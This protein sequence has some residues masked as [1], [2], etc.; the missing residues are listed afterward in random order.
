VVRYLKKKNQKKGG[1]KEENREGV[2]RVSLENTEGKWYNEKR[3][4]EKVFNKGREGGA[5]TEGQEK[6]PKKGG[7]AMDTRKR[8]ETGEKTLG[9]GLGKKKKKKKE[10]GEG[11]PK[12][13]KVGNVVERHEGRGSKE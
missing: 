2:K 9:K 4:G 13:S 5:K 12:G 1:G 3:D 11:V 7:V 10:R 8:G 6:T